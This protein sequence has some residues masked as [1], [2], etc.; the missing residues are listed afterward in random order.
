MKMFRHNLLIPALLASA[1][2]SA[3]SAQPFDATKLPPAATRPIDFAR[4]IQPIIAE[5]CYQCHGP[6]KEEATLRLDLKERAFKGG[7]SGPVI[8]PGKS[9]ESLLIQAVSRLKEDLKMPKKGDPLTA[10]QIG[11][12]R[13]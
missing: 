9:A 8:I 1:W 5:H 4:D 3:Q 12:L 11:L 13:A 6:K 7:E 10:E 2:W